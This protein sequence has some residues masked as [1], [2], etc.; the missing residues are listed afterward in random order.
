MISA[1][2]KKLNGAKQFGKIDAPIHGI[3]VRCM[4]KTIMRSG[5][6]GVPVFRSNRAMQASGI[7]ELYKAKQLSE[8]NSIVA[9][10]ISGMQL[11]CFRIKPY[12][13][14]MQRLKVSFCQPIDRNP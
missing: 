4:I 6:W 3:V 12:V 7:V 8:T 5:P 11:H 13:A 14:H 9:A 2:V 1:A 10:D